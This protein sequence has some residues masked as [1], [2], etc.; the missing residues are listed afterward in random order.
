[1]R[2]SCGLSDLFC[3]S[4]QSKGSTRTLRQSKNLAYNYRS[5][6]CKLS[7]GPVIRRTSSQIRCQLSLW[8]S[9][10]TTSG[11]PYY[12]QHYVLALSSRYNVPSSER[13]YKKES[14]PFRFLDAEAA[15]RNILDD[16]NC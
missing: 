13:T 12:V 11:G 8:D 6:N 7:E 5:K 2:D 1:M 16:Q 9:E 15:F 14:L 4:S 3:V 10:P